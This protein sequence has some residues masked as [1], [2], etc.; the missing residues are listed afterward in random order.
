MV[1]ILVLLINFLTNVRDS[2][3]RE[4][5]LHKVKGGQ[6]PLCVYPTCTDAELSEIAKALYPDHGHLAVRFLELRQHDGLDLVQVSWFAFL[7]P[8]GAKGLKRLSLQ[9]RELA[10]TKDKALNELQKKLVKD[11]VKK[12]ATSP[13]AG[14]AIDSAI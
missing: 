14:A 6:N 7:E 2:L 4:H 8:K 9:T 13:T 12:M 5:Q 1:I 10:L 11:L 3:Q